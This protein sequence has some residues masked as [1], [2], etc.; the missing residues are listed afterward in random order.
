MLTALRNLKHRATLSTLYA[1][2]LRVS[3]LCQLRVPDVD[4]ARMVLQIQQG[5][6]Q[7]DR[8]VMLSPKLLPLLRCYWQR[9][10]PRT[11]LFPGVPR[12]PAISRYTVHVICR[13]A[14]RAAQV[15]K[16]VHPQTV[17]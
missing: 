15:P 9:Y 10:K 3:E 11:W 14:G 5:K 4:S 13:R 7:R 16:A 6:G 1:A 17:P 2:G 12:T 8:L